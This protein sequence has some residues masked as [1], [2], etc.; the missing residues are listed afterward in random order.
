VLDWLATHGREHG[1]MGPIIILGHSAG[2]HLAALMLN[3]PSF[4]LGLGIAGLYELGPIRDTY[5][6]ERLK[7][8]DEEIRTMSP[9]HLPSVNKPFAIIYG[10]TELPVPIRNSRQFHA[11]RAQ[12]HHPG[13]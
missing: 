12:S 3:H 6:N 9:L 1:L 8:T 7:L 10:S 11:Y 5:L 2:G 4:K 13:P